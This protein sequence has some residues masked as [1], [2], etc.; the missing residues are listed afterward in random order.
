MLERG[1]Y[2][3]FPSRNRVP[4]IILVALFF[5][6]LFITISYNAVLRL[7]GAG[8]YGEL[9]GFKEREGGIWLRNGWSRSSEFETL[10]LGRVYLAKF[11]LSEYRYLS[12]KSLLLATDDA[13]AKIINLNS[14]GSLHAAHTTVRKSTV[15]HSKGLARRDYPETEVPIIPPGPSFPFITDSQDTDSTILCPRPSTV[16]P[17]PTQ[18]TLPTLGCIVP[19]LS[20]NYLFPPFPLSSSGMTYMPS[21]LPTLGCLLPKL[22]TNYLFSPL[23]TTSSVVDTLSSSPTLPPCM[24]TAPITTTT[25]ISCSSEPSPPTLTSSSLSHETP[26]PASQLPPCVVPPSTDSS[27]NPTTTTSTSNAN[28]STASTSTTFSESGSYYTTSTDSP[29]PSSSTPSIGSPTSTQI[30]VPSTSPTPRQTKPLASSAGVLTTGAMIGISLVSVVI[31]FLLVLACFLFY[32]HRRRRRRSLSQEDIERAPSISSPSVST[33]QLITTRE[34]DSGSTFGN[35]GESEN[36]WS[37]RSVVSL[38]RGRRLSVG[39]F[40]RSVEDH[41][42]PRS[43]FGNLR[44][45]ENPRSR[46]SPVSLDRRRRLSVGDFTKSAEDHQPP[47]SGIRNLKDSENPVSRMSPISLDRRRKLSMAEFPSSVDDKQSPESTNTLKVIED[48]DV[49]S[50]QVKALGYGLI[51]P[52]GRGRPEVRQPMLNLSYSQR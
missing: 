52:A 20:T 43:G 42:P 37:R 4:V 10:N 47:G 35:W 31:F 14:S 46:V 18:S 45:S 51:G 15:D 11:R 36:H 12:I 23:P 16:T 7:R 48:L 13:A 1:F 44:E 27:T 9:G 40:T 50:A 32:R 41:Q 5:W 22:S 39:D 34:R 25:S 2:S 17:T 29:T 38:D 49:I 6:V 33:D 24:D 30:S 3:S 21:A 28:T 26:T 19:H 8:P